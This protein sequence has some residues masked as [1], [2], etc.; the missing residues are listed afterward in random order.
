MWALSH[1]PAPRHSMDSVRMIALTTT[2]YV[3]NS[4]R[5]RVSHLVVELTFADFGDAV[6]VCGIHATS[7]DYFPNYDLCAECTSSDSSSTGS[8]S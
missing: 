1:I 5:D 4:V 2:E 8:Q 3:F 7:A 6:T